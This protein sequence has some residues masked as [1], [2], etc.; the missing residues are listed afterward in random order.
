[1]N[2]LSVENLS[3]S[4]GE[5]VL[6]EDISFGLNKGQ[7]VS[8]VAKN[9][10]G[11]STLFK[12]L[13]DPHSADS[14]SVVFR[15]GV[16]LGYLKQES[17]FEE[18]L[19]IEQAILQSN[20]EK[21]SLLNRYNQLIEEGK[22]E[23]DEFEQVVVEMEQKDVWLLEGK[24]KEILG[25]L[26][27]HDLSLRVDQLS[28]GQLKRV[29]LAALLLDEPDLMLLDE[30]TNHL[31]FDMIEW[32]EQ[33]LTN[34]E[35]TILLITHDRYFLD[36][37]CDEIIE[38]DLQ[39]LFQYK[40]GYS[41]YLEKKAEREFNAQREVDKAK[42][43]LRTELEWYRRMPKARTTKSKSRMD[44]VH[45]LKDKA[46]SI[47]SQKNIEIDTKFSRLGSKIC[48][49][50]KVSYSW[51]DLKILDK[52]DYVFKKGERVGIVGGN[53]TGKSTF[54]NILTQQ[55]KPQVGEVV[56]GETV[57]I[58][59]Y[60][61]EGLEFRED[62]KVIDILKEFAE[63]VELRDGKKISASQLLTKFHFDPKVQHNYVAKLSGGEKRR[64]YLL[65]ILIQSP[66]FLILDEPTN[67]LDLATLSTLEE[68]LLDFPGCLIIVSHDR[69]F[70]DRLCDHLF[71][72]KGNARIKDFPG[73][74]TEYREVEKKEI[75]EEKK[76]EAPKEEPVKVEKKETK[77]VS[78]KV[79]F[80]FD[81][82]E[83]RME[84]LEEEKSKL[85]AQI[86]DP[87][88][89]QDQIMELSN[90][91]GEIVGELDDLFLKWSELA[92]QME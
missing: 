32:L 59:H 36:A 7:K 26:K 53:G 80:E 60:K 84:E 40:G 62:H 69:S 50:R 52:F 28:G 85:E 45:D 12:L 3:K 17:D 39:Q 11:K 16:R 21:V 6:F 42:N 81:Q 2:L 77:K 13:L 43:L 76:K 61:Q 83:K 64:L 65:T 14:G 73:T 49:F 31:D 41:Y 71:V 29:A 19:T 89:E 30:P 38:I 78:Y 48:E 92:E 87:N 74:Y 56:I 15:D 70:L 5:R 57:V 18:G 79:Q 90:K 33:Y 25:N 88:L 54:L 66:N 10:S 86:S 72:F 35:F 27:I 23:S 68:Y 46:R 63:I 4:Y 82:T 67:D 24:M 20:G 44:A 55:I 8:L 47:K 34:P 75:K 1:M 9:G 22:A 58:G 91:M 51:E 37:V